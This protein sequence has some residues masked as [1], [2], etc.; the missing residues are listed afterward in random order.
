[1]LPN[2]QRT[3]RFDLHS[4]YLTRR[5]HR[6]WLP[7]LILSIFP[8]TSTTQPS[9][10]PHHVPSYAQRPSSGTVPFTPPPAPVHCPV[11][12]RYSKRY[13][14]LQCTTPS[15]L[16]SRQ[17]P[18]RGRQELLETRS[19]TTRRVSRLL[20]RFDTDTADSNAYGLLGLIKRCQIECDLQQEPFQ[21]LLSRSQGLFVGCN[22]QVQLCDPSGPWLMHP[23][24]ILRCW[25]HSKGCR[26]DACRRACSA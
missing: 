23:S 5:S 18:T 26:Q 19:S 25:Q 12:T 15:R 2:S 22:P 8:S 20:A 10:F 17:W 24:E 3:L 1:V 4:F 11:F 16:H 13:F 9:V 21:L 6:S 14:P 7:W